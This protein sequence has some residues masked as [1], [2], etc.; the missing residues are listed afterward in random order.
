MV[1]CRFLADGKYGADN[2]A[3]ETEKLLVDHLNGGD[4]LFNESVFFFTMYGNKGFLYIVLYF[5][6]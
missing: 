3:S 2:K 1:V 6:F 5:Y 4:K